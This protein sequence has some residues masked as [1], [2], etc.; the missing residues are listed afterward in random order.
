MKNKNVLFYVNKK[1]I[2]I[3]IFLEY[4]NCTNETVNFWCQTFF[5]I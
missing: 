3:Y 5:A 1:E 2:D 4:I